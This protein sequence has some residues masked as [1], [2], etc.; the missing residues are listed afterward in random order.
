[1]EYLKLTSIRLPKEYLVA[2]DKLTDNLGYYKRSLILRV[3]IWV[4]LKF[5]KPGVLHKLLEMMWEEEIG[6]KSYSLEDVLRT[7]GTLDSVE[8]GA[9]V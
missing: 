5:I 2:A 4:G 1:M 3:A 9:R 8:H 7:A 6:R